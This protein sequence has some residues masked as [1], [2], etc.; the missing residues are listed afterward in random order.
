MM[1]ARARR[2]LLRAP[3]RLDLVDAYMER[4][5]MERRRRLQLALVPALRSAEFL[6]DLAEGLAGVNLFASDPR[7]PKKLMAAAMKLD[8]LAGEGA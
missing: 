7:V 3:Q 2:R 8:A 1:R 4:Q 5:Y 6:S